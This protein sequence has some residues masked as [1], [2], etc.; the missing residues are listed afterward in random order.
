MTAQ[1]TPDMSVSV[2]AG[3][4]Y[5][6]DG[7]RFNFP[8]AVTL[9]ATAD[10]TNPRIDIVYVPLACERISPELLALPLPRL[11]R[12]R[13]ALYWLKS[14]W[15]RA[16]RP[17]AAAS[18]ASRKKGLF[19]EDWITPTLINGSTHKAGRPLQY[20]KTRSDMLEI[21]R[22]DRKLPRSIR[23]VY[24]ASGRLSS[25]YYYGYCRHSR[26]INDSNWGCARWQRIT[27]RRRG[28][29]RTD[30]RHS[31]PFDVGG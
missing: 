15:R 18:I 31:N 19:V 7:T 9:A 26:W 13:T 11:Q 14:A 4:C 6:A 30:G 12:L 16:Q 10:A 20:R 25:T 2:A 1:S 21:P 27:I 8:S 5:K 29:L 3:T 22:T 28:K 17:V 24:D 23:G